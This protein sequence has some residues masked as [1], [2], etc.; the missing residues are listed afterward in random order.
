MTPPDVGRYV[1]PVFPKRTWCDTCGKADGTV[2]RALVE[3]GTPHERTEI[4]CVQCRYELSLSV[5]VQTEVRN[6]RA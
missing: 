1:P 6:A 2:R 4:L 5:P 3:E